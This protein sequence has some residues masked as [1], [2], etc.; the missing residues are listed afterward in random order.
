VLAELPRRKEVGVDAATSPRVLVAEDEPSVQELVCFHLAMEGCACEGVGDGRTALARLQAKRFDLLVA[1]VLLPG[2]DGAS[3]CRAVRH[4]RLN[5]DIPILMVTGGAGET[6]IVGLEEGADDFVSKPLA[7]RELLARTRALLQRP[8]RVSDD[9]A[10]HYDE[11]QPVRLGDVEIDP[12]RRSVRVGRRAVE[13]TDQEFRLLHLLASHAGIVFSRDALLAKVWRRNPSVTE[14]SVDTLIKRLR[15]RVEADSARP[16]Y[17][18]TV[19]G[20]G[21]KFVDS[22]R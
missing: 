18:L 16:R 4:G 8:R 20:V 12:A 14:R 19:W 15:R 10:L 21:Y 13:L 2:I 11:R 22:D 7:V 9:P 1:G 6:E 3:L 5:H 17:L